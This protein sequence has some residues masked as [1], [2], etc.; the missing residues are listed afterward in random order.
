M[1]KNEYFSNCYKNLI[2]NKIFHLIISFLEFI[3]TLTIQTIIFYSK[4]NPK[5]PAYNNKIYFKNLHIIFQIFLNSSPISIKLLI[6]IILY[7]FISIYFLI[8]SKY[9]LK[10]K[11]IHSSIII[12]L[13]EVFVFRLLFIVIVLTALTNDNLFC[14]IISLILMINILILLINNFLLNHLY[15]F[16]IHFISYPYDCYSSFIDIIFLF[17]KVLICMAFNSSI[18]SFNKFLFIVVFLLQIISFLFSVY[19]FRFKSYYIM[20]NIFLNKARFS[21]VISTLSSNLIIIIFG[22][23]NINDVSNFFI[24][25]LI[26]L[27]NYSNIL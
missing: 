5:K 26:Y 17:Q 1:K 21:F 27:Y 20:N 15:Y 19:I 2:S 9:P 6:I 13:F 18:V 22:I 7:I 3:L 12:N 25:V 11:C 16:S 24:I 8:Y 14:L 4:Y 10:Q 23:N